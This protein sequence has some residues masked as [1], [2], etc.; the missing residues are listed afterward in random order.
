[1]NVYVHKL[2]FEFIKL[3]ILFT[4]NIYVNV[5]LIVQQTYT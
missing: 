3:D 4:M 2:I 5:T 1:M